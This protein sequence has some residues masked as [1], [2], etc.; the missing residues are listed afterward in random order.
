MVD[1]S[2]QTSQ[3]QFSIANLML[4]TL[5]AGM[6]SAVA[7]YFVNSTTAII[8]LIAYCVPFGIYCFI[9]L[10]CTLRELRRLRQRRKDARCAI[11]N[12]LFA[13]RRKINQNVGQE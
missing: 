13:Q 8:V 1:E 4:L 3:K 11:E 5:F 7:R 6:V 12:T 2:R 9:R 10:P